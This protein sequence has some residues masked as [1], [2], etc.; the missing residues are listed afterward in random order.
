MHAIAT[1]DFDGNGKDDILW[2]G[3]D[4][5]PAMWLMNGMSIANQS[6]IGFNPGAD[7]H[8]VG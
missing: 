7:W 4:G 6:L 5:T 1:G 3:N 2:Q 8:I